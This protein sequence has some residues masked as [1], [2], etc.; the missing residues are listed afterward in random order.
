MKELS[1]GNLNQGRVNL[2]VKRINN[3]TGNQESALTDNLPCAWWP[4]TVH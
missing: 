3:T 4:L 1:D 2:V